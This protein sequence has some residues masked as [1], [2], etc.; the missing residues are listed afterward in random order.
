M[1][2]F[3]NYPLFLHRSTVSVCP[4]AHELAHLH[5]P[6]GTGQGMTHFLP[7]LH[8]KLYNPPPLI[9]LK[10]SNDPPPPLIKTLLLCVLFPRPINRSGSIGHSPRRL[11]LRNYRPPNPA[12]GTTHREGIRQQCREG[13]KGE[14]RSVRIRKRG[15]EKR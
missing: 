7:W 14:I 3:H 4:V 8:K 2:I 13:T 12:T 10:Y 9:A 11:R 6:F 15:T 5:T 1:K